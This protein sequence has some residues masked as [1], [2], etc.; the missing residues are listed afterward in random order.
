MKMKK[1]V[2]PPSQCSRQVQ[3]QE[4]Q[5]N[6]RN[7]SPVVHRRASLVARTLMKMPPKP[8]KRA[9]RNGLE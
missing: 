1:P 2:K 5:G 4:G 3:E 8:D 7:I 6:Q 9:N